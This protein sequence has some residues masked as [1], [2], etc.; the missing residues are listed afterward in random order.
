MTFLENDTKI[1]VAD[2]TG[3]ESKAPH[4]ANLRCHKCEHDAENEARGMAALALKPEDDRAHENGRGEAAEADPHQGPSDGC[5]VPPLP[6]CDVG[7]GETGVRARGYKFGGPCPLESFPSN[8][9]ALR[10]SANHSCHIIFTSK[11]I[12]IRKHTER[13]TGLPSSVRARSR[14]GTVV[15]PTCKTAGCSITY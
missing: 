14:G 9:A 2:S 1:E 3:E 4:L 12:F 5:D 7:G 10:G 15:L 11:S 6:C 13:A 8:F